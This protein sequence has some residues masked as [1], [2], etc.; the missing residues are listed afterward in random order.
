MHNN[1]GVILTRIASSIGEAEGPMA[2]SLQVAADNFKQGR[3]GWI[4]MNAA[5][6]PAIWPKI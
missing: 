3:Q 1:T 4:E 2:L 5:A 6:T